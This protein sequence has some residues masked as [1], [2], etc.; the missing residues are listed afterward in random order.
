MSVNLYNKLEPET[1]YKLLQLSDD[2]LDA[3]QTGPV[4]FKALSDDAGNVVL[5]SEDKTWVIKQR[6]HSNTVILMNEFAPTGGIPEDKINTFGL[7]RPGADWAGFSTLDSELEPRLVDGS[8]DVT[9]LDIYHGKDVPLTRKLTLQEFKDMCPCSEKEFVSK[10]FEVGGS[11]VQGFACLLSERFMLKALHII[12]ISCMAENLDVDSLSIDKV[13]DVLAKDVKQ[14]EP[15]L[16]T[17]EIVTTVINKFGF[18]VESA[19]TEPDDV[20]FRI[21][22]SLIARWY[23]VS[24]LKKF[25]AKEPISE[26]E[27]MIQWKG[28]FPPYF[29]CDLDIC[30]LRGY[31]VRPLTNK[32][33]YMSRTTLSLDAKERFK[34]LFHWQSTWEQADMVP[35]ISDLNTKNLKI[36]TF[37]IKYA[38]RKRVGNKVIISAR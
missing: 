2:L 36:D 9:Q 10:W 19:E 4:K 32:I 17:H 35:Y 31:F 6:N 18:K 14:G 24:A 3:F 38:R 28:Q 30:M 26:D 11:V 12:L 25:A 20:R 33:R 1:G 23:G 37:I 16:Y 13:A 27:F 22:M 29:H 15:N 7:P 5:C 8:I 34:Q 21:N